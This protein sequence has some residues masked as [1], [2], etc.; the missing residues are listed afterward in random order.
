MVFPVLPAATHEGRGE[1]LPFFTY[2][3]F[4]TFS[5]SFIGIS[6]PFATRY[7]DGFAS[8][9]PLHSAVPGNDASKGI[10]EEN[11]CNSPAPPA[12]CCGVSPSIECSPRLLTASSG[13]KL[14]RGTYA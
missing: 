3:K 10:M 12:C 1:K 13:A 5:T 11:G 6:K 4:Q 7:L 9:F 8:V 2:S 14:P